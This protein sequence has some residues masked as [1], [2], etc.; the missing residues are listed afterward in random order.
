MDLQR[1]AYERGQGDGPSPGV[2]LRRANAPLLVDIADASL[3][4]QQL[5]TI[6]DIEPLERSRLA[7]P[8]PAESKHENES[9]V[10]IG[11]VLCGCT[12]VG[13]AQRPGR[14]CRLR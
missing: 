3:D 12:D 7:K 1:L 2:S 10:A 14:L 5:R 8:Q 13:S 4:P 11:D 9:S 6:G